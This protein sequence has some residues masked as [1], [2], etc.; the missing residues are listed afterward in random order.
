MYSHQV[1]SS[2]NNLHSYPWN[3]GWSSSNQV[4]FNSIVRFTCFIQSMGSVLMVRV[5]L[6]WHPR[7]SCLSRIDIHLHS[8]VG[9]SMPYLFGRGIDCAHMTLSFPFIFLSL[10]AQVFLENIW[11]VVQLIWSD[12]SFTP[13]ESKGSNVRL[14][15]PFCYWTLSIGLWW[16]CG[17]YCTTM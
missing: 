3:I 1:L 14:L 4:C 9:I 7:F 12:Y 5:L 16:N 13:K 2:F 6:A 8:S 11:I 17:V 10:L 15:E